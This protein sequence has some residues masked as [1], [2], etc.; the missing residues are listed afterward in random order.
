MLKRDPSELGRRQPIK[1][2][3]LYELVTWKSGLKQYSPRIIQIDRMH[4]HNG[5]AE[6]NVR[7]KLE[8]ELVSHR[9][10][11]LRIR[12]ETPVH[13]RGTTASGVGV[14]AQ[15]QVVLV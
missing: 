13:A 4:L 3:H 11:A 14:A 15:H 7:R 1:V 6:R 12:R 9:L 10:I 8:A 2:D 5:Q